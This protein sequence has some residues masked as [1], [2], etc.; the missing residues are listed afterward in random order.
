MEVTL[1]SLI[2]QVTCPIPKSWGEVLRY[3]EWPTLLTKSSPQH[4][5]ATGCL[6][7]FPNWFVLA[8]WRFVDS[9]GDSV[10]S[11]FGMKD[12]WTTHL[13][14]HV[15]DIVCP[16]WL[17]SENDPPHYGF[18]VVTHK[19][20]LFIHMCGSYLRFNV[21]HTMF[22]QKGLHTWPQ[23]IDPEEGTSFSVAETVRRAQGG[24]VSNYMKEAFV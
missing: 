22:I 16:E 5:K 17:P 1:S 24:P 15:R 9:L 19:W 10:K 4:I 23:P 14:G 2:A 20:D 8:F 21:L 3:Q 11:C 12:Q 6:I 7:A 18:M 13:L